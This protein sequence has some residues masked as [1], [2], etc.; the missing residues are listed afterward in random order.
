MA[1][2]LPLA[3][4]QPAAHPF[5][6]SSSPVRPTGAILV[7]LTLTR[8]VPGCIRHMLEPVSMINCLVLT[9]RYT[10]TVGAPLTVLTCTEKELTELIGEALGK[11]LSGLPS[12]LVF[13]RLNRRLPSLV[14]F[15]AGLSTLAGSI[16]TLFLVARIPVYR[17]SLGYSRRTDPRIVASTPTGIARGVSVYTTCEALC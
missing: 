16:F 17:S 10:N 6:G 9:S 11:L 13:R 4:I 3:L 14:S 12:P 8:D 1:K 15:V 2:T 7:W 5:K